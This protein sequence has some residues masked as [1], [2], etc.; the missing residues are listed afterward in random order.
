MAI[1]ATLPTLSSPVQ[2]AAGGAQTAQS[3]PLEAQGETAQTQQAVAP[4]EESGS[5]SDSDPNTGNREGRGQL[6]DVT[7]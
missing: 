1:D 3:R 4:A 5:A 6:V 7:V 2:P